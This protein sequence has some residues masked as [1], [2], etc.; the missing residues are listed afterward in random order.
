MGGSDS[1]K[2]P[3]SLNLPRLANRESL[4][5]PHCLHAKVSQNPELDDEKQ[6]DVESKS[7]IFLTNFKTVADRFNAFRKGPTQ[8]A[9][10]ILSQ[11]LS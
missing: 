7:S 2:R 8:A 4:S 6:P 5:G 1:K 10:S 9:V 3:D 11:V